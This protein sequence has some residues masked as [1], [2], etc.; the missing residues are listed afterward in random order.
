M[1]NKQYATNSEILS[2]IDKINDCVMESEVNVMTALVDS[3]SKALMI[4]ENCSEDTDVSSF[5]IIQEAFVIEAD[6]E[7]NGDTSTPT[8]E[9]KRENLIIKILMAIPRF[10]MS[11]VNFIKNKWNNR[12]VKRLE[13]DIDKLK[14]LNQQQREEF[15]ERINDAIKMGIDNNEKLKRDIMDV[16]IKKGEGLLENAK[17]THLLNKEI[18]ELRSL[19]EANDKKQEELL[20]N[21][22]RYLQGQIDKNRLYSNGN[23]I[24]IEDRINLQAG[25]IKT[26][27]DTEIIDVI[28]DNIE[29]F[30][31]N[32]KNVS[33]TKPDSFRDL[34]LKPFSERGAKPGISAKAFVPIDNERNDWDRFKLD[35]FKGYIS[36]VSAIFNKLIKDGVEISNRLNSEVKIYNSNKG[37]NQVILKSDDINNFKEC[38]NSLKITIGE[39]NKIVELLNYEMDTV[40]HITE[41]GLKARIGLD[42]P[43]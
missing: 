22:N 21:R 42:L 9:T 20:N 11:I 26:A 3:Y 43:A 4:M 30:F 7:T 27:I 2:S 40:I 6:D 35:E 17:M 31:N 18:N 10:I 24:K 29:K 19:V 23:F 33:I 5:G 25:Y 34:K 16:S 1:T 28:I 32:L 13:N 36:R 8:V 15:G 38:T 12:R 41:F 39:L 37:K 14:K